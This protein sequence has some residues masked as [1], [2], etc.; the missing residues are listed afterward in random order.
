MSAYSQPVEMLLR[1]YPNPSNGIVKID[2]AFS[3][4]R[5]YEVIVT[6]VVGKVMLQ[7][8]NQNSVDLSL[9]ENGLYHFIVN[10]EEGKRLSQKMMLVK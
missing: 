5:N 3:Y 10:T 9:F 4:A 8:K 2:G 6:D 7:V 1:L